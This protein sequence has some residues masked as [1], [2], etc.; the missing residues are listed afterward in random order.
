MKKHYLLL[1]LLSLLC[2]HAIASIEQG[3]FG[4]G[5]SY[6]WDSDNAT[7]T[8]EGTGS[9]GLHLSDISS[10]SGNAQVNFKHLIIKGNVVSVA[11][12]LFRHSNVG[13][14][15]IDLSDSR[16][17]S[18]GPIV[19]SNCQTIHEVTLPVT[20]KTIKTNAFYGY[21]FTDITLTKNIE[22]IEPLA[23]GN[24]DK[25]Q[26]IRF[27]ASVKS[28]DDY[29]FQNCTSLSNIVFESFVPSLSSTAFDATLIERLPRPLISEDGKALYLLPLLDAETFQYEVPDGIEYLVSKLE[30]PQG[31]VYNLQLPNTL[32]YID[33][34]MF[35]NFFTGSLEYLDIPASVEHIGWR[36]FNQDVCLF[37]QQDYITESGLLVV[38]RNASDTVYVVPG[39]VKTISGNAFSYHSKLKEVNIPT[40]VMRINEK[41]FYETKIRNIVVPYT[42]DSIGKRAFMN[43]KDLESAT[44]PDGLR[45]ISDELFH[46]CT[47]LTS[48]N[49]PSHLEAVGRLAFT[50]TAVNGSWDMPQSVRYIG[51]NAFYQTAIGDM[52]LDS[53]LSFYTKDPVRIDGSLGNIH[54]YLNRPIDENS[55]FSADSIAFGPRFK[56]LP[57]GV[58]RGSV[59]NLVIPETID[60]LALGALENV[61]SLET[62]TLPFLGC[63]RWEPQNPS[64]PD[65]YIESDRYGLYT[66]FTSKNYTYLNDHWARYFMGAIFGYTKQRKYG[67]TDADLYTYK[68]PSTLKTIIFTGKKLDFERL[69]DYSDVP[70]YQAGYSVSMRVYSRMEQYTEYSTKVVYNAYYQNPS[71]WEDVE[72][73]IKNPLDENTLTQRYYP[74]AGGIFG[75]SF[76]NS[77]RTPIYWNLSQSVAGKMLKFA[78]LSEVQEIPYGIFAASRRLETIILPFPGAGTI[79]SYNCMGELFATEPNSYLTKATYTDESGQTTDYYVPGTLRHITIAEGCPRIPQSA[80]A[81][82]SMLESV[83]L[84]TTIQGV[85][86]YAFANCFG[87][88]SL[89]IKKG[90]PPVAFE[91]SFEG[92]SQ[93]E[94]KLL[95]PIDSKQY[96]SVAN[97]WKYFYFIEEEAPFTITVIKNIEEAGEVVGVTKYKLGETAS[98][99]AAAHSGYRF[100]GWHEGNTLLSTEAQ[101]NFEVSGDRILTATYEP[102]LDANSVTVRPTGDGV[103]LTWPASEG[104]DY[105]VVAIY[106]DMEMTQLVKRFIVGT[107]HFSTR[108]AIDMNVT[109]ANLLPADMYFYS[110]TGISPEGNTISKATGS[111]TLSTEVTDICDIQQACMSYRVNSSG[112]TILNGNGKQVEIYS[113]NG[114]AIHTSKASGNEYIVALPRGMYICRIDREKSFKFIIN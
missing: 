13:I 38:A 7:L 102:I 84:P 76:E 103:T 77:L 69:G 59:R 74:I 56:Y 35:F 91:D 47:K 53:N 86:H 22:T 85:M 10:L 78:D 88:T 19:A 54:L 31:N 61:S 1:T 12:N 18:L 4:G 44:L 50:N 45:R 75:N 112:I 5:F 3:T 70:F 111:F 51:K 30:I 21:A 24:C 2:T 97:G 27:P 20:L 63:N 80:F 90:L 23:F 113:S 93:F 107:D 109:I 48:V 114:Y 52:L 11:D 62:I 96:Y 81:N 105:Y 67:D 65:N 25:L 83:S 37:H 32:K 101:Y 14:E 28:I 100:V 98:F 46:N 87:M 110:I 68:K 36:A 58:L 71:L 73:I 17:T 42:V 29:A 79:N 104:I 49:I 94:C 26:S 55:S 34:Q 82:F 60:S 99:E 108:A 106:A 15:T 66:P 39:N 40:S 92:C 8:I 43:C 64:N 95:V 16:I 57:A 72:L 41:A 33:E 6:T 9:T 89:Q